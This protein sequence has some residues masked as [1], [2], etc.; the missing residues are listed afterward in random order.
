MFCLNFA[1]DDSKLDG[2]EEANGGEV[3][4]D[5]GIE[6]NGQAAGDGDIDWDIDV[7]DEPSEAAREQSDAGPEVE[8]MIAGKLT[9]Q[10]YMQQQC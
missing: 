3:D 9:H 8:Q 4:W 5:F 10:M 7:G 2:L 1:G 6:S